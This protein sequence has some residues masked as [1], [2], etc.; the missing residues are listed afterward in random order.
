MKRNRLLTLG[1]S[2]LLALS[3]LVAPA[4]AIVTDDPHLYSA[5][6]LNQLG[7]FQGVGTNPDGSPDYDLKSS[8][9]REQAV[10]ML[11][12]LLGKDAEALAGTWQ[13]PFTDVADWAK[14]YVGYA[15]TNGL[16]TGVTPTEFGKGNATSAQY[17]TFVLRALGYSSSVDFQWEKAYLLT[18]ELSITYPG[19]YENSSAP[20]TRGDVAKISSAA[21]GATMKEGTTLLAYLNNAGVFKDSNLSIFS[22]DVVSR[23]KDKIGFAFFPVEGT[24]KEYTSFTVDSASVNGLPCTIKQFSDNASALNALSSLKNNY[25]RTFN[26]TELSYDEA[27][28]KAAATRNYTIDGNTYPMLIF[29][30]ECTGTLPDGSTVK[31]VLSEGVYIR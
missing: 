13:T 17:L 26:Y 9:T 23:V 18:H 21:L 28:A 7:L 4:S 27:A 11:V 14:P 8:P 10:T 30:F 12:R 25:P 22:L 24:P 31:E 15:Y 2:A 19:E 6:L 1:L 5:T 16:T 29:S 20:F 3:L